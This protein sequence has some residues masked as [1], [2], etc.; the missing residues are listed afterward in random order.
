MKT[1]WDTVSKIDGVFL[2]QAVELAYEAR[3]SG[4]LPIGAVIVLDGEAVAEGKNAIWVP[5]VCPGR[6]AEIEALKAVPSNLWVRAK[7]M[8]L[9]TTLEPCVMCTGAILAHHVGRVVYGS[10][11]ERG[12]ATCML[13]HLPP[14][15]ERLA[16]AV[17]WVGPALPQECDKLNDV[18]SDLLAKRGGPTGE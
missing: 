1:G 16:Q 17:E 11:D 10:R 13:G 2:R 12:G 9:Y 6:H 15:F 5:R 8:T 4:N 18:V 7:E 3:R 14:A